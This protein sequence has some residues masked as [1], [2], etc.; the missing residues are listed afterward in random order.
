MKK[1]LFFLLVS[2]IGFAQT[3]LLEENFDYSLGTLTTVASST[4]S[5][6]PTGST[7]I[8]V[9]D[10]NLSFTDY[11]SSNSGRMI[12]LNGGASSRSGVSTIFT[13]VSGNGNSIYAS[14]LVNVTSTSD[15]STT[16]DYFANFDGSS[17]RCFLYVKLGSN[18]T[19]FQI[20]IAKSS[21]SSLTYYSSELDINTTYLIVISYSFLT[22]SD[23]DICRL[24]V[25]PSLAGIEPIPDVSITSGADASGTL[26]IFGFKQKALSGDM[27][28][29]GLRLATSW[30]QAPLPVE[31][32][33]FSAKNVD[34]KIQLNWQTATEVDNYG[35]DVERRIPL[36]PPPSKKCRTGLVKGDAASAEG[37]WE[38]IGF[39]EGH[40]T[41]NSPKEYSFTDN[42]NLNPIQYRL[43]QIDMDG[44]YTYSNI[45]EVACNPSL[46]T[47]E[48]QQ[49]YPNPFN[50]TTVISYQL[51]VISPVQLKIYDVLG[52]EVGT[53]VDEV[54]EPG[55]YQAEFDASNLPS[56]VYF[57]KLVA[58]DFVQT[59]KMMLVR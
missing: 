45:V 15:M 55:V 53:L 54:K 48:L 17:T 10:G 38:T 59:K 30:S 20:G 58:G 26:S 5:E 40:G 6:N 43:K 14:I 28:V 24:W 34:N 4:W 49:N 42:L 2:S 31:L 1:L 46:S 25:N 29:D 22:G 33:S 35:F 44:S 18:S 9:I 51:S 47:F 27:N 12:Y 50:P 16:A 57:Y 52:N 37:D 23:N 3:L 21:S 7:D 39:V 36:N 32:S 56:G 41:S 8:Q 11:P 19:K 13:D